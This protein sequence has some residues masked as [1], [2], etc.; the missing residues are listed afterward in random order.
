MMQTQGTMTLLLN[1]WEHVLVL[2][3][4]NGRGS[5]EK[6][7]EKKNGRQEKRLWGHTLVLFLEE[8][9]KAASL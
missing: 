6:K 3:L 5:D 8:G 7:K 2:S 1:T 9:M 4:L